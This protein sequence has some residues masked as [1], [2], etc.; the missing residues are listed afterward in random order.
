MKTL[1]AY[2]SRT[3]NTKFVAQK[4]AQQL[5]AD[6]CE[7]VDKKNRE[8]KLAYLTG[9]MDAK[10]EKLT[11]IELSKPVDGFDFLI[12]GSPVWAGKI[13][14]AIRKFSTVANLSEKQVAFF[15]TLGGDNASPAFENLKKTVTPKV[16]AELAISAPLGKQPEAEKQ[17]AEWC[18]QLR[19]TLNLP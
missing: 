16:V 1:V 10:R 9:G 5:G 4:I 8:G 19:K 17:V 6:V 2:Y 13:A 7:V 11:E 15:V 3:G 12:V 14:P 18:S